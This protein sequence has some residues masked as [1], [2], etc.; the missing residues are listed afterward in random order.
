MLWTCTLTLL[1]AVEQGLCAEQ[2]II[3]EA[4]SKLLH[5]WPHATLHLPYILWHLT[6]HCIQVIGDELPADP[7][8]LMGTSCQD[9]EGLALYCH[10][11]V[12]HICPDAKLCLQGSLLDNQELLENLNQAKVKT[13]TI[14]ASLKQSVDLQVFHQSF[15]C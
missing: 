11:I 4:V 13:A 14:T 8:W 10:Y 6:F 3:A 15:V 5:M 1:K 9:N 7:F 2:D 12:M